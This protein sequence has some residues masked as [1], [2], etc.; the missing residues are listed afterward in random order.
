MSQARNGLGGNGMRR[1]A[2]RAGHF[3][4]HEH[5]FV[6]VTFAG[7]LPEGAVPSAE[8][9][10][11]LGPGGPA[12][13]FWTTASAPIGGDGTRMR[14]SGII[15]REAPAGT[16][17]VTLVQ[18]GWTEEMPP[19]WTPVVLHLDNLGG[20]AIIIVDPANPRPQPNLPDVVGIGEV[21]GEA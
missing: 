19:A 21:I 2:S 3:H 15:P 7:P 18:I 17:R 12:L 16:Y 4:A 8:F 1:V 5:F 14:L 20:D 11:P 9:A 6:E 13:T 10:G